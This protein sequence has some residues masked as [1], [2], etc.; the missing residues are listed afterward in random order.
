MMFLII[1]KP[2]PMPLF[3]VVNLGSKIRLISSG[4]IPIPLSSTII[5]TLLLFFYRYKYGFPFLLLRNRL[6]GILT[7][8]VMIRIMVRSILEIISGDSLS[9]TTSLKIS[10]ASSTTSTTFSVSFCWPA[11]KRN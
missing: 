1:P 7:K 10:I 11:S 8:L 6:N 4:L 9:K 3:L 5:K 2:N